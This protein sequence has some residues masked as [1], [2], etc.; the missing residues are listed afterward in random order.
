MAM[1]GY[2]ALFLL[3]YLLSDWHNIAN[4]IG[5]HLG[6]PADLGVTLVADTVSAVR[7]YFY[8]LTMANLPV[9]AV[10]G[11]TMV[12]LGLPLAMPVAVVTMVTSYIPYLGALISTVFAALV[13]LGA[14][15]ISDAIIII[16]V[17]IVLQ[18]VLDPIITN[19]VASDKLE[20]H[21]IVTLLTTLGGGILFGALGAMLASPVIA[22]LIEARKAIGVY[23]AKQEDESK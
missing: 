4:W 5:S 10:V 11:I 2:T 12:L 23:S 18:N 13:A 17:I 14:G 15:G 1:G 19:F 8:A 9:A 22:A 3:Y 6:V 21:P 7:M 16:V 20:M